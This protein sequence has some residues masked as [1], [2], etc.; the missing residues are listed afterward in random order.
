MKSFYSILK[1][2][3]NIATED[4]VAIGMLLFD[5]E[6]FRYYFSDNK[7][8]LANTLLDNKNVNV[9]F[10]I[11]QIIEKCESINADKEELKIFYNFDKLSDISYFNYLSNYANGLLQ[12]S[13]PKGL[14]DEVSETSFE[15]LINFLFKESVHKNF[16]IADNDISVSRSIIKRKLINKVDHKVHTY[17]KFNPETFPSIYFPFEMDCIGLN[18]SLIGAKSLS[19]NKSLQVLDKDISH[20]FTLLS[21]LTNKYNKSLKDNNFYLISEEPEKVGSKEHKLWESVCYNSL[22]SVIH[23]EESNKV[24]DL[25]IEK[26][27]TK[28]LDIVK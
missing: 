2:S 20:Y 14:Y 12:F 27:A 10:I 28:F 5:G 8:R 6:K 25:I 19:F 21:S 17:Y 3:P 7:K 24:A 15:Q 16:D 18:G 1:L 11:N 26:K 23:P 22:I 13:K 9:N 4:S